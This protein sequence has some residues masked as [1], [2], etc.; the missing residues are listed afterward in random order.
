[1]TLLSISAAAAIVLFAKSVVAAPPLEIKGVPL[2]AS[3]ADAVRTIP[4]LNCQDFRGDRMCT[5]G[6]T[7]AA[8][9]PYGSARPKNYIFSFRGDRLGIAMVVLATADVDGV[10]AALME[11]YGPPKSDDRGTIQN[12]MGATFDQRTATWVTPE[13]RIVA[14]QRASK[15]DE[16]Q[17]TFTANWFLDEFAKAAPAA[18]KADAKSL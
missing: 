6:Q 15:I 14:T 1:M 18:A 8:A 11:K 16:G 2:G 3:E 10:I 4:A 7:A 9:F 13:G 5:I 12:R 17:I